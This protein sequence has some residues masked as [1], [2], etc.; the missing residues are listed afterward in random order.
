MGFLLPS[1]KPLQLASFLSSPLS[2]FQDASGPTSVSQ[3]H[4]SASSWYFLP[5]P[6]LDNPG[7]QL[8]LQ[9]LAQAC[10]SWEARR[11]LMAFV[12]KVSNC[13]NF[14]PPLILFWTCKC[15]LGSF[16]FSQSVSV[17][18]KTPSTCLIVG[19]WENWCSVLC[20]A[21]YHLRGKSLLTDAETEVFLMDERGWES[22]LDTEPN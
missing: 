3:R 8:Q 18:W 13:M 10:H 22:S 6:D 16:K 7:M 20:S 4:S 1:I 11:H 15:H 21:P 17:V 5:F 19:C 2:V 9:F 12:L 14:P